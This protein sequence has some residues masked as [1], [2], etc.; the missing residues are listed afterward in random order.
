M[1]IDINCLLNKKGWTGEELGKVVIFSLVDAY[2]QALQGIEYPI[3]LFTD[4]QFKKMLNSIK[5]KTQLTIYNRY[6]GLNNWVSQNHA[7]ASTYYEQVRGEIAKLSS[8]INVAHSVEEN[9]KYIEKLPAIMTQKQ[10]D[11]I[12]T[13][14]IEET[15]A[16]DE[17]KYSM[18]KLLA[19]ALQHF[20][21]KIT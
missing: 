4:A 2:K 20:L 17:A 9:Y 18:F 13:T 6:V 5:E 15:L 14:T 3:T 12:C 16:D 8:I 7:I 19:F 11:D 1:A 10:Y 21:N